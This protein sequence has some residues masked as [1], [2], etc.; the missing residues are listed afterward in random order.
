M[1]KLRSAISLVLF[2]L[3]AAHPAVLISS[4]QTAKTEKPEKLAFAVAR[5]EQSAKILAV[6]NELSNSNFPKELADKAEAIAV[7]PQIGEVKYMFMR[8]VQ[9]YG[10]I[11]A[12]VEKGWSL[13]AFYRF[14]GGSYTGSFLSLKQTGAVVL[15]FMSKE[16]L[17]LF[18]K[19][20]VSLEMPTRMIPGPVGPLTEQQKKEIESA[21]VLAYTYD[22][23]QL[24][25][26]RFGQKLKTGLNP[27]NNVN[28][29]VYGMKGREVLAG[30]KPIERSKLP[31]GIEAFQEALAKYHSR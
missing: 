28:N 9:G 29:S 2:T 30:K 10:V 20:G 1:L 25:G 24:L 22:K 17:S 19:G 4:T 7:F 27:D 21:S 23:S 26:I 5:S 18:D 6:L 11:C 15:L 16:A 3:I 12:R 8:H 31:A 14:V 13:P